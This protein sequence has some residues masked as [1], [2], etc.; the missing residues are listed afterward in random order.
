MQGQQDPVLIW[1]GLEKFS[2]A[3]AHD[4]FLVWPIFTQGMKQ[5]AQGKASACSLSMQAGLLGAKHSKP[6]LNQ[7]RH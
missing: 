2:A 5:R 7:R 3:H 4:S 1:G 6:S